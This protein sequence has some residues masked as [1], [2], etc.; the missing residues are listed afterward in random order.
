MKR[1]FIIFTLIGFGILSFGCDKK[2]KDEDTINSSTY[3]DTSST[4]IT[5]VKLS[6]E[7][8]LGRWKSTEIDW[9]IDVNIYE[10]SDTSQL[11]IDVSNDNQEGIKTY[12]TKSGYSSFFNA[13]KSISYSFSIYENQLIMIM[14]HIQEY[15][16][17][18]KPENIP[19][20]AIRPWI[21][22]K[23]GDN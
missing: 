7:Y 1:Y 9:P 17:E 23:I 8:L 16:S 3:T 11:Q 2:N 10:N 12:T 4:E 5:Q 22:E 18:Q 20:N 19:A 21:L 6:K 13:D 15:D 14:T